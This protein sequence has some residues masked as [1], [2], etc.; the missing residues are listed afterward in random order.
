MVE[1]VYSVHRIE[2]SLL[3]NAIRIKIPTE[4]N[5]RECVDGQ[6]PGA[7][8][9]HYSFEKSHVVVVVVVVSEAVNLSD[10][11]IWKEAGEPT[12]KKHSAI[13]RNLRQKRKQT[14][15]QAI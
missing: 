8:A 10:L 3:N 9:G 13:T 12:E 7:G 15:Q 14:E 6:D 4:L 11:K 1:S 5:W 2:P